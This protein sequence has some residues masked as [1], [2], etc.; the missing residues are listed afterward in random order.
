MSHKV[1]ARAGNVVMV[2]SLAGGATAEEA[3]RAA[4]VSTRTVQRRLLD[5]AFV[6][7][8]DAARAEYLSRTVAAL[9]EHGLAATGTL[10]ELTAAEIPAST[11]LGA[12]K[13]ILELGARLRESES[14]EQRIAALEARMAP[15]DIGRH[16]WR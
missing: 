14:L 1:T 12:A 9:T 15:A 2:A 3:A 5:P 8:I 11:R 6:A 4:G 16:Q 10:V 7:A 13:A